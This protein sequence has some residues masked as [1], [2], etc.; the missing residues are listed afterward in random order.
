MQVWLEKEQEH[1][2]TGISIEM[3]ASAPVPGCA[4]VRSAQHAATSRAERRRIR[5]VHSST[6]IVI[7]FAKECSKSHVES[8]DLSPN[9]V[10]Q[11]DQA[12][13]TNL[14]W[15]CICGHIRGNASHKTP[16]SVCVCSASCF[17]KPICR[18]NVCQYLEVQSGCCRQHRRLSQKVPVCLRTLL[19]LRRLKISFSWPK[20]HVHQIPTVSTRL[21][22]LLGFFCQIQVRSWHCT[23]HSSR[24]HGVLVLNCT[25]SSRQGRG[26]AWTRADC[27]KAYKF[28]N[29][30]KE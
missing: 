13:L 20:H 21:R 28:L 17:L 26:K 4:H 3:R 24:N 9:P 16:L 12:N 7:V 2:V 10:P 5:K 30:S 27:H 22:F 15:R 14:K 1:L 8:S 23:L 11:I 18:R 29:R 6:S 25:K 19:N